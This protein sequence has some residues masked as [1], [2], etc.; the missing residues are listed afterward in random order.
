[1]SDENIEETKDNPEVQE[2]PVEEKPGEE[3]ETPE[4]KPESPKE[5]YSDRE[6]RLYARVKKAEE[7]AKKAKEALSK[8]K[9]P[10]SDIDAILEVQSST[11]DLDPQEIAELKLRANAGDLSL[12]E[13]RKDPNYLLWQD[14]YRVKVE[15]ENAAK[16]STL[17]PEVEKAKTALDKLREADKNATF[18]EAM[19][20]KAKIL[21]REGLWKEPKRRKEA[22]KI[23]LSQ[24]Q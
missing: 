9:V 18:E 16:P 4:I 21:E 13:A 23:R 5:E 8:A 17:Q 3:K 15:K 7:D 20:N 14:A 6:K 22:S 11:R 19:E 1:M 24:N 2:T 10:I 12:T